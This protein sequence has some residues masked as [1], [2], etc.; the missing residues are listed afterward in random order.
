MHRRIRDELEPRYAKPRLM[1][2]P[3][4]GV[5]VRPYSI[6]PTDVAFIPSAYLAD[7]CNNRAVCGIKA[8]R[9]SSFIVRSVFRPSYPDIGATYSLGTHWPN[10]RSRIASAAR[11]TPSTPAGRIF[12]S[13][14]TPYPYYEALYRHSLLDQRIEFLR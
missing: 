3:D 11:R 14:D 1:Q 9:A 7:F 12:R 10:A 13:G 4:G 6:V 8:R 5:A 2:F